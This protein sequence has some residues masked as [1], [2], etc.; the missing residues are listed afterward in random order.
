MSYL[1]N[2]WIVFCV[3]LQSSCKL[4]SHEIDTLIEKLPQQEIA[5]PDNIPKVKN[6]IT[7]RKVDKSGIAY[8]YKE[9]TAS[10]TK[11]FN[12]QSIVNA[13]Y[14]LIY[15]GSLVTERSVKQNNL[16]SASLTTNPMTIGL[17]ISHANTISERGVDC[18][19]G[20]KVNTAINKILSGSKTGYRTNFYSKTVITNSFED[21]M[22]KLDLNADW[23]SGSLKTSFA[24]NQSKSRHSANNLVFHQ[25]YLKAD[26]IKVMKDISTPQTSHC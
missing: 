7:K 12:D 4:S 11:L 24:S 14:S 10:Y 5:K 8:D 13:D 17:N 21:A 16:A 19:S 25:I 20:A 22:F 15:P 3:I 18:N 6:F 9:E 23:I 2:F 26:F 1:K